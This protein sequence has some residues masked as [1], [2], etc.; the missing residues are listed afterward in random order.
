MKPEI[1][2]TAVCRAMGCG[3]KATT[4]IYDSKGRKQYLCDKHKEILNA[5]Q[6]TKAV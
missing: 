5:K 2:A 4:I 1:P 3:R 6:R